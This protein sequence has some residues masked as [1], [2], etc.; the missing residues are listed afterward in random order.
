MQLTD[1]K[2]TFCLVASHNKALGADNKRRI[3][4]L[5]LSMLTKMLRDLTT[6]REAIIGAEFNI[7]NSTAEI[8]EI[9]LFPSWRRYYLCFVDCKGKCICNSVASTFPIQKINFTQEEKYVLISHVTEEKFLRFFFY[10]ADIPN[11]FGHSINRN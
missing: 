6:V 1:S 3:C 5:P 4:N 8:S 11:F 2:I 10:G 7:S 9:F